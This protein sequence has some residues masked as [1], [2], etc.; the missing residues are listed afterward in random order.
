VPPA[1]TAAVNV[2][3]CPVIC[4]LADDASVTVGAVE[5]PDRAYSY[6][7]PFDELSFGAP[8]TTAIPSLLRETEEPKRVPDPELKVAVSWMSDQWAPGL[9]SKNT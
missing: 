7:A 9:Q 6:A 5:E 8:A 3:D 1:V 4:G 2:T